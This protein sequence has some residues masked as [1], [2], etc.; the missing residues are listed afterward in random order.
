MQAIALKDEQFLQR[1]K[2][3]DDSRESARK[4]KKEK[5]CRIL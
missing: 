4:E 5:V 3:L 2:E 1:K